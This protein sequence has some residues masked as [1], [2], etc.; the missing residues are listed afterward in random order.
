[1]L[2]AILKLLKMSARE[3]KSLSKS[4]KISN[5]KKYNNM[6]KNNKG[7]KVAKMAENKKRSAVKVAKPKNISETEWKQMSTKDKQIARGEE[8][9]KPRL[10]KKAKMLEK[11][12][13]EAAKRK[14]IIEEAVHSKKIKAKSDKYHNRHKGASSDLS[15]KEAKQ[16]AN[17]VYKQN[18]TDTILDVNKF[19]EYQKTSAKL[20]P[21]VKASKTTKISDSEK[22][23]LAKKA[24]EEVEKRLFGK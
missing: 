17:N 24:R 8:A 11:A 21:K 12:K 16:T 23:K 5:I 3:W 2:K 4:E 19:A 7:Y 22:R 1:M 9:E 14:N 10:D 13:E 18:R 15:T 20:N 6:K